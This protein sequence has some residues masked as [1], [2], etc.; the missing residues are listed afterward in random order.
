M[1]R[2][3]TFGIIGENHLVEFKGDL[4]RMRF[5]DLHPN[6][7]V[8]FAES[9]LS[10]MLGNM[11]HPFMAIYFAHHFGLT[12]A[13]LLL[14][15][16]VGVGIMAGFLGGP[17]ADR[18]GRKKVMVCAESLRFLAFAAMAAANSPWFESAWITFFMACLISIFWGL[19]EP[20]AEAM[21]I[22]CSTEE[23]RSLIYS[24]NYWVWNVTVLIGGMV[25]GF[26]F[27]THLFEIFAASALVSI[28]AIF[29]LVFLITETYQPTPRPEDKGTAMRNPLASLKPYGAVLRNRLFMLFCLGNLL[30]LSVE[31]M[32]NRYTSVRLAE[33]F[34][35]QPLF[36]WDGWSLSVDGVKMYGFLTA[37]NTLIVVM[38]GLLIPHL[39]KRWGAQP[40]LVSGILLFA[41]GYAVFAFANHPWLLLGVMG[42][43]TVGELLWVPVMQTLLARILPDDSRSTYL[44]FHGL[45]GHLAMLLG[46]FAVTLGAYLSS[47]TMGIL[48][49]LAGLISLFLFKQTN[50]RLAHAQMSS[51]WTPPA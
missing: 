22:D 19:A 30:V 41:A 49:L 12:M 28:I 5:R 16:Q 2:E 42:L 36:A 3:T 10:N 46:S 18:I 20:A 24:F 31:F 34:R 48:F 40:A 35:E 1:E 11:T 51:S 8:R 33:E 6:I 27:Q 25:G 17:L 4:P 14:A 50:V 21:L 29:M 38:L 44:A 43:A 15:I 9:F 7:K 39:V 23:N 45:M 32:A 37:E 26:L 13:G 47:A